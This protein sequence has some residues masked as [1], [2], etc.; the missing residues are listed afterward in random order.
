[1]DGDI[2]Y[3]RNAVAEALAA[4]RRIKE[5]FISTTASRGSFSQV[6]GDAKARSIPVAHRNPAWLKRFAGSDSHQGIVAVAEGR[7]YSSVGEMLN[8]ARSKGENPFIIVLDG[9]EDPQ[10]LGS[11]IRSA[12]CAGAHGII[13]PEHHAVGITGSV[14]KVASGAAEHMKVARVEDVAD[15]LEGLREKGVKVIGA[16]AEAKAIYYNIPMGGP[17]AIVIGSEGK[18]VRRQIKD[19]CDILVSIP[20]RGKIN[21]LNAAV[22]AAVLM[23]EAVRQRTKR[24]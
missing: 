8:F 18:G 4:K 9:I 23:F 11:V 14:A 10:N 17:V 22:A 3:G 2:I 21:S 6:I 16:D 13:I 19:C 20:L 7:R 15:A 1:V 12:E 5:I 24:P